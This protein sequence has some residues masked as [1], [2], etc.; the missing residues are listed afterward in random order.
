MIIDRARQ[1]LVWFHQLAPPDVATNFRLQR[2]ARTPGADVVAGPGDVAA[3]GLGEGVI[4][5]PSYRT[6]QD[7]PRRQR[8]SRR[9]ARVPLTP[10]GDALFTVYSPVLV[11]PARHSRRRPVAAA[12]LDRAGGRRPHRPG[13]VGVACLR[14]HPARATP[15]PRPRPAPTSTPTT[16]T[17]SSRSAAAGVLVSARDTSAVYLI[18]RRSGADRVDAGRQGEQLPAR[19]R[20]ALLL[21]ARRP[22]AAAAT[23]VSCSTTRPGRRSR[24]R[25]RAG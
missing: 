1:R 19:A 17:R 7:R 10:P 24:R 2:L 14:A 18:D 21:P 5:D 20:G 25:P 13:R 11:A 3:F 16:S 4:A 9:S 6:L 22:A 8:L 23:E 12:R 15:T